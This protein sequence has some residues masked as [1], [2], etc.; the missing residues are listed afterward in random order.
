MTSEPPH[1]RG[2]PPAEGGGPKV[3]GRR[4]QSVYPYGAVR[5]DF[6]GGEVGF[7]RIDDILEREK[8]A[9]K[10]DA[11]TKLDTGA[12]LAR[13]AAFAARVGADE[14]FSPA[15]VDALRA[16]LAE[17]LCK[18]RFKRAKEVSYARETQDLAALPGLGFSRQPGGEL[19]F[20]LAAADSKRVSALKSLTPKRLTA[21]NLDGAPPGGAKII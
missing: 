15:E 20:S 16:F 3:A 9:N 13:L 11:W 6:L 5:S 18:G 21:R 2:A 8:E 19:A 14:A 7:D 12:R 4:A 17:R 10:L 1:R